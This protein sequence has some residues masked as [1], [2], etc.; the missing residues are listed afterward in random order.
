M[1]SD[2]SRLLPVIV[3]PI[4]VFGNN[5]ALH[6]P[7]AF[8]RQG[9][10]KMLEQKQITCGRT[11]SG[12][13][14]MET[15]LSPGE[16]VQV[17]SIFGHASRLETIQS[18]KNRLTKSTFL[19]EKRVVANNLVHNL[20]EV[21]ACRTGSLTF[22]AYCRQTFLDNILRGG[23]PTIIGG[24]KE[25]KV[26]HMY[27]RKHG[28]LERDYNDFSIEPEFYSQG[29]G[30][31]RDINQNRRED[32]WFFPEIGDFNIRIFMSLIQAD[33]YNPLV[34]RGSRFTIPA[35]KLMELLEF[36]TEPTRLRKVL[37]QSFS[38][39]S[40]LKALMAK[41]IYLSIGMQA[42]LEKV[43]EDSDQYVEVF[44]YRRILD[45]S[46]DL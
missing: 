8:Y 14:A 23:L 17:N 13:A 18:L 20:T 10:K 27:S 5:S 38:P 26:I 33:G 44:K 4:L 7:E 43:I 32:V 9:L 16:S 45:R 15:E 11:P 35:N 12:F 3:D 46:L 6:S 22:D 34:L 19:D 28:D 21:I 42:F 31:F 37:S 1:E 36:S 24:S 2:G 29:S 25:P 39:G 41:S 40:L 30:S